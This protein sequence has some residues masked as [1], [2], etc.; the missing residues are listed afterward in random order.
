MNTGC[1]LRTAQEAVFHEGELLDKLEQLLALPSTDYLSLDLFDTFFRRSCREPAW[2]FEEAARRVIA[3][4]LPL[5]MEA[6][7]YRQC[8]IEAEKKARKWTTAEDVTLESIFH[9]MPVPPELKQALRQAEIQVER[10]VL[11]V[12]PLARILIEKAQTHNKKIIFISDIYLPHEIVAGLIRDKYPSLIFT[13]LFVSSEI[14]LTKLSGSLFR[15]VVAQ[16]GVEPEHIVHIGDNYH[17]DF[18]SAKQNGLNA[19]H[20]D[21]PKYTT[22]I[23]EK[24]KRYQVQL[25]SGVMHARKLALLSMPKG[26]S[27]EGQFFY[28]Y[29]TFILGPVLVAFA[30]W[31]I[32][33]AETLDVG[34]ILALM[35]EGGIIST[36]INREL[37]NQ[38]RNDIKCVPC[39]ASRKATFLPALDP[40][41]I[42]DGLGM[43]L[44]RKNYTVK[45]IF[46]EF[47]I[48][49]APLAP[50]LNTQLG[51]L[52]NVVID[53]V[54]ALTFIR[55]IMDENQSHLQK[56]I[57]GKK[58]LLQR[59][60][61][62]L[63]QGRRFATIDFGGGATIQHQLAKGLDDEAIINFLVYTTARG[64][65]K[66]AE[67]RLNSFIPYEAL[68]KKGINLLTRSPEIFEIMLVG[69]EQT[70]ITYRET[71]DSHVVPVLGTG[72]YS[73]QH[74]QNIDAF[75]QGVAAFQLWTQKL[76]LS[77]PD[78]EERISYLRLLER[79]IE[80][81][82]EMEVDCLGEL[83]HEDNFGSNRNYKI[84][85]PEGL[86]RL[87]QEGISDVYRNFSRNAS[88]A[89]SWLAWPQGSMTRLDPAFMKDILQLQSMSDKHADAVDTLGALLEHN[90]VHAV[91][92]YGA[93][94]FFECLLPV[95]NKLKVS[96]SHLIDK[97]A[98]FG[99]YKVAGHEVVNLSDCQFNDGDVVL[100]ASAAYIDEIRRDIFLSTTSNNI[101]V[102]SL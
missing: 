41:H 47:E 100:I 11:S 25:P 84:V 54:D 56:L 71:A 39:Y 57:S 102:L 36:C 64:Y 4:G 30:K 78:L 50:Y 85:Q 53:G 8:R 69:R 14:G 60:I 13:R 98:R 17:A 1:H 55:H 91:S 77:A 21:G 22:D 38:A 40:D 34:C 33:R 5:V 45:D 80:C 67:V 29:G 101:K 24:E 86:S 18:I 3:Q 73:T 74:L 70:T 59:Y 68:T 7:D 9:F 19:I 79:L 75:E 96:I 82:E 42:T 62:D 20:F 63:T 26:L 89:L 37:N 93:G 43:I 61:R 31:V 72:E 88:Y 27:A 28:N 10:E 58:S 46:A 95:L 35:R 94:E 49:D 76:G 48:D 15:H 81:P 44:T 92:V 97:K 16:L 51:M 2:V 32:Q 52:T 23:L 12:D 65:G 83:I 87:Q 66:S 6:L 90:N 99:S